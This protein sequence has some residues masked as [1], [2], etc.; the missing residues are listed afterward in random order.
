M[1]YIRFFAIGKYTIFVTIN[2]NNI[3]NNNDIFMFGRGK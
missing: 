1:S 3:F 2:N